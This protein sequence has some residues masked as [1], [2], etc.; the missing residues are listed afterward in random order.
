MDEK[1]SSADENTKKTYKIRYVILTL[2]C[3]CTFTSSFQLYEQS[4]VG[5]VIINYYGVTYVAV[6]WTA[7]LNTIPNIFLFYPIGKF[8]DYYG[9]R[10]TM[11]LATL[12]CGIGSIIKCFSLNRNH[13][14][15]LIIAKIFP[16]FF[17]V[18]F[19]YLAP[20]LGASWFKPNEAGLVIGIV[21]AAFAVGAAA[22]F[23]LPLLFKNASIGEVKNLFLILSLACV[24][25]YATI[26]FMIMLI[27]VDKPPTPPSLAAKKRSETKPLPIKILITNRNF[28]LVTLTTFFVLGFTQAFPISLNQSILTNFKGNEKIL[29]LSGTLYLI[30]KFLG[31][32]ISPTIARKYPKYKILLV[33][34]LIFTVIFTMLYLLSLYLSLEWLLYSSITA[35]GIVF[36]GFIVLVLDYAVEVSFP[37]PESISISFIY[38]SYSVSALVITQIVT[39]L[40]EHLNTLSA[41]STYV[42]AQAI[43]ILLSMFLTREMRRQE[44][45]REENVVQ[46]KF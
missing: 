44:A 35:L 18:V 11:V 22:T 9:L 25:I 14:W 31:G 30:S 36:S 32:F 13:Y 23:S 43:G 45:D 33:L 46:V 39:I 41:Y 5:N 34:H 21:N 42:F 7:L 24:F 38:L 28:I 20:V 12:F 19:F 15:I 1:M 2:L 17:N 26:I 40:A 3:A 16:S 37:F 10:K 6:S 27:V 29:S 4:S 8:I